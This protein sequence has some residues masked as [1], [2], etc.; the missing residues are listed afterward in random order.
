MVGL[1]VGEVAFEE[2]EV[3]VDV[4]DQPGASREQEH[5]ADT[6]RGKPLDPVGQFVVDVAGG[7][8]GTF[9]I[10]PGSVLDAAEDSALASPERVEDIGFHSK[11]SVV[12][13]SEDVFLPP[14]FPDHRG[15][16]SFFGRDVARKRQI[17]LV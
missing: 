16:S 2:V 9:A 3:P 6:A 17:T 4:V 13:D 12:W 7:D 8:H 5:G 15:F 10:G 11:A 14:L 1:M